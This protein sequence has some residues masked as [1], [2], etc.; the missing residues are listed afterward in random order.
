MSSLSQASYHKKK[1]TT[2]GLGKMVADSKRRRRRDV[3][4]ERCEVLGEMGLLAL[5]KNLGALLPCE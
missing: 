5:T 1:K 2:E 3:G 4:D